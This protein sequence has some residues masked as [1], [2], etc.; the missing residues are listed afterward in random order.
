LD[1]PSQRTDG[2]RL[3]RRRQ[4]H[5][6]HNQRWHRPSQHQHLQLHGPGPRLQRHGRGHLELHPRRR[7]GPGHTIAGVKTTFTS[8][9]FGQ[10]TGVSSPGQ[11]ESY[12]YDSL[13][14]LASDGSNALDY[15]DLSDNI[16]SDGSAQYSWD[17]TG[18]LMAVE[19]NGSGGQTALT[20][21]HGDVVGTLASGTATALTASNSYDP[22][23][24]KLTGAVPGN[25]GYQS[26]WTDP[27]TGQASFGARWYASNTGSFTSNDRVTDPAPNTKPTDYVGDS[28]LQFGD[29]TGRSE[30][31]GE[32]DAGEEY[33]LGAEAAPDG[34]DGYGGD[35]FESTIDVSAGLEDP[36]SSAPASEDS[37][38]M[39]MKGKTF[40]WIGPTTYPKI[41]ESTA[42]LFTTKGCMNRRLQNSL[43]CLCSTGSSMQET[44][45]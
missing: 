4:P 7:P 2:L 24:T 16:T 1:Q 34:Q 21:Q 45:S 14:R 12:T 5:Q 42:I 23:G 10:T 15:A 6:R 9:A 39:I 11:T 35:G 41:L 29:P 22:W 19:T 43:P 32:G 18:S 36:V 33:G 3:R 30:G 26:A 40:R 31:P 28:P 17:P 20:D 13:G 25:I 44:S 8:D 38:G 27:V 37:G